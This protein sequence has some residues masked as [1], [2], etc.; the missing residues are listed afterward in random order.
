[1]DMV[2]LGISQANLRLEEK[3]MRNKPA[4]GFN[5]RFQ[6]GATKTFSIQKPDVL[7]GGEQGRP[8]IVFPGAV[9]ALLVGTPACRTRKAYLIPRPFLMA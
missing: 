9:F 8:K 6:T 3:K 1:M 2:T 7:S 5:S 4:P